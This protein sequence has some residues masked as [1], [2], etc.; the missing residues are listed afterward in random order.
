MHS[1]GTRRARHH[2]PTTD[3]ISTMII[4][5]R[6]LSLYLTHAPSVTTTAGTAANP[7]RRQ[8][9]HPPSV[10]TKAAVKFSTPP[11][12]GSLISS[13]PMGTEVLEAEVVVEVDEEAVVGADGEADAEAVDV[14]G[15]IQTRAGTYRSNPHHHALVVV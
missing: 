9:A 3:P 10:T 8:I 15:E 12:L 5:Q 14:I 13:R 6:V 7:I 1:A 11:R 4:A 2:L